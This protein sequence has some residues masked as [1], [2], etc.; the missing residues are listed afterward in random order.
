MDA[1]SCLGDEFGGTGAGLRSAAFYC[2]GENSPRAD[3]VGPFSVGG[4]QSITRRTTFKQP[5]AGLEWTFDVASSLS[6]CERT[7]VSYRS[8][9]ICKCPYLQSRRQ[10][11]NP[12]KMH[13]VP[14]YIPSSGT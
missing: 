6:V 4:W 3:G 14:F 8:L 1:L 7:P 9:R 12:T 11:P 5:K 2:Q 10:H 13:F